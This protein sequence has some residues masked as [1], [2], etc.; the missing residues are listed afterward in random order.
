MGFFISVIPLHA[1]YL[2]LFHRSDIA[3]VKHSKTMNKKRRTGLSSAFDSTLSGLFKEVGIESSHLYQ[4]INTMNTLWSS[5]R[6]CPA[7]NLS[8][9]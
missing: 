1:H 2:L 9:S 3:G 8:T 6:H 7:Q 5:Y 4:Q